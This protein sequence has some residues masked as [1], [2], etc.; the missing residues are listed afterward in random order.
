[1]HKRAL[2][3]AVASL[4][5][6]LG[7]GCGDP[8]I[9]DAC[10]EVG[11]EDGVNVSVLPEDQFFEPGELT[12]TVTPAGASEST[13]CELTIA[14]ECES[15][16]VVCQ[17]ASDSTCPDGVFYADELLVRVGPS[18][19]I[20]VVAERDGVELANENLSPDLEEFRPN[21]AGCEPVCRQA[22][23]EV[24]LSAP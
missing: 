12:V 13:V 20:Q 16:A 5:A 11:C 15:G 3:F 6:A 1:M 10:T 22:D 21:G 9:D 18:E 14:S 19:Q 24:T 23:V 7:I 8:I 17:D 4:I 2:P